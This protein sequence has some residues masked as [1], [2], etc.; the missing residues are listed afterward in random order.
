LSPFPARASESSHAL[1]IREDERDARLS[2]APAQ[3]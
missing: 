3:G 1:K 2:A